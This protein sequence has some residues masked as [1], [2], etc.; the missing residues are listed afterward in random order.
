M[1]AKRAALAPRSCVLTPA[2]GWVQER[3]NR[4]ADAK[5][6]AGMTKGSEEPNKPKRLED[7]PKVKE[8]EK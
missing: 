1:C 4:E 8:G 7:F 3:M 2:L 6:K 5:K